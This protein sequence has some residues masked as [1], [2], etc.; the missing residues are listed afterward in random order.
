[1]RTFEGVLSKIPAATFAWRS[2][3][4]IALIKYWGKREGQ[5]PQNPSL[6]MTLQN[7][8]TE[9]ILSYE[10]CSGTA[11]EK[12]SLEFLFEGKQN[13]QFAKR[14][15]AFLLSLLP[16]YPFLA[17]VHL[18]ISSRNSFPH[19]AGIAS[20]ASSMSALALCLCSM[21]RHLCGTLTNEEDFFRKASALAR[22]ASG[23]A[24][25]SLY[26]GWVLWGAHDDFPGSSQEVGIAL[27]TPI[28]E[29]FQQ[30]QNA[31]LVVQ[32][33]PKEVSS[34]QGHGMMVNHPFAEPRY[35][36]ANERMKTLV[37]ALETGDVELV[38]QIVEGEAMMLHALM[39][40]SQPYFLLI[41]PQTLL[42]LEKIRQFR[43]SQ[44]MP[45]TFTLDAGPNVH[46][47]YPLQVKEKVEEFIVREL[48]PLCENGLWIKDEIGHGPR[49]LK[50]IF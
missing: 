30:W 1:M 13:P 20:S 40:S 48:I 22:L 29:R 3:S 34:S 7:A 19:S 39:M 28:H 17:N 38:A 10:K 32:A 14:I 45:V 43:H 26:G 46:L 27:K 8:Y 2:P 12:I 47:L 41:R 5:V 42:L 50:I 11:Q 9:M 18:N 44:G 25:R 16:T 24:C 33:S 23:S 36:L 15:G 35:Q 6:S 49:P 4:N 37:K 21:E 31:I